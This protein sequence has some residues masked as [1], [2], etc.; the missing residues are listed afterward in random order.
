MKFYTSTLA[1]VA[2]ISSAHVGQ[3]QL[4][5]PNIASR[6]WNQVGDQTV[7][8][9]I[10]AVGLE[11]C[12]S[13]ENTCCT[14]DD[15]SLMKS[16]FEE[17]EAG[18]TKAIQ[19]IDTLFNKLETKMTTLRNGIRRVIDCHGDALREAIPDA[20]ALV[21]SFLPIIDQLID[22]VANYPSALNSCA[23][24]SLNFVAGMNCFACLARDNIL[25][26]VNLDSP[27][28]IPLSNDVCDA[29][30]QECKGMSDRLIELQKVISN[31]AGLGEQQ[32]NIAF[33]NPF[34]EDQVCQTMPQGGAY[35]LVA[36]I[37]DI[38]T[39]LTGLDAVEE[40]DADGLENVMKITDVMKKIK[41]VLNDNFNIHDIHDQ[42]KRN[43]Q[44]NVYTADGY[45]AVVE[46]K[47]S[48]VVDAESFIAVRENS[49]SSL[50]LTAI[51]P[52]GLL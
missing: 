6:F 14:A 30:K 21:D 44:A 4:Q 16:T 23:R 24:V 38:P 11:L 34:S 22:V 7:Q 18:L 52:I 10:S 45:E 2:V 9:E 13:L 48:N 28:F 26:L 46:G 17:K 12:P 8:E 35:G 49:S 37:K 33:Y 19:D 3:A 31:I 47:K 27:S 36:G 43:V 15:F 20:F 41:N 5:C 32:D 40:R 29:F 51:A 42:S 50:V 1:T 39:E 25:S